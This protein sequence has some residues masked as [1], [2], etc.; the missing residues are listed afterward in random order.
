ME[1]AT[2]PVAVCTKCG[3]Y[4]FN[5]TSI[6][7]QCAER[8]MDH[9]HRTVRCKGVYGS[10]LSNDDWEQ[11][12]VCRRGAARASEDCCSSC[13]GTGWVFVRGRL[14]QSN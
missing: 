13:Q 3:K 6:N 7:N 12:A 10:A 8:Y 4:T 11:C 9:R 2:K 14:R 1:G 5:A